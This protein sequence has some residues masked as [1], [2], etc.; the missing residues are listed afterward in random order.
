MAPLKLEKVILTQSQ[1]DQVWVLSILVVSL[2]SSSERERPN[3]CDER[4]LLGALVLSNCL[5]DSIAGEAGDGSV[6][7]KD[8]KLPGE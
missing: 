4:A 6:C 3:Q 7:G 2:M 8:C 5:I 1:L